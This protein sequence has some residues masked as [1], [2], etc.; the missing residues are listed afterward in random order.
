MKNI[1]EGFV[2]K[3][4]NIVY[5]NE[6]YDYV[7]TT[8]EDGIRTHIY[9]KHVNEEVPNSNTTTPTDNTTTENK[10]IS[11]HIVPTGDNMFNTLK[12]F[13]VSLVGL[14]FVMLKKKGLRD[15]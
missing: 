5:E 10:V 6:Q 14:A 4:S 9:K 8:E 13:A 11:D 7:N 2:E 12:Y 3:D 1:V 15:E